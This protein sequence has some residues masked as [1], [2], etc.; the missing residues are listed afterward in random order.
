MKQL[1]LLPLLVM[2][3]IISSFA[4]EE[5]ASD[6]ILKYSDKV[7]TIVKKNIS[8]EKKKAE[9]KKVVDEILDYNELAKRSLGRHY[10]DRSQEEI[11]KFNKLMRE[12]IETS[13]L[14]KI[15]STVDYTLKI[16]SEDDEEGEKIVNTEISAKEGK[17]QVGFAV[18][19]R[20]NKWVVY[21]LII[22]DV[23]TL[24]NYKSEFNKI[25]KEQG[26]NMV[27]KKME[28]KLSELKDEK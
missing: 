13:Y 24:K 6:V 27:I 15:T 16:L 14:K 9:I 28:N 20:D 3:P 21:D 23:S 12:L 22:D 7:K 11:E 2:L 5:K 1:F 18:F 19:K 8:L 17:V 25:I 4:E 26:F 10:R